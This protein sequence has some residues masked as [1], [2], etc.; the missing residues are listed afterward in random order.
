MRGEETGGQWAAASHA[1]NTPV[2]SSPLRFNVEFQEDL[3]QTLP[4]DFLKERLQ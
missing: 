3:H 1:G 4:F 2:P